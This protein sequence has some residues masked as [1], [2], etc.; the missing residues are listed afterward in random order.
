MPRQTFYI[1]LLLAYA[2]AALATVEGTFWDPSFDGEGW[3][4]ESQNDVAFVTWYTYESDGSPTFRAGI[5]D[6]TYQV[7]SIF[8]LT[9]TLTGDLFK[10]TDR[11]NSSRVGSFSMVFRSD[12]GSLVGT[13]NVLG[14]S[15]RIVPFAFNFSS[16]VDYFHGIWVV[17]LFG[18]VANDAQ[19]VLFSTV[20][21]TLTDGTPAKEYTI[22]ENNLPGFIYWEPLVNGFLAVTDQ[23]D[24]TFTVTQIQSSDD[25][26]IG[27]SVLTDGN[28]NVLSDS[29]FI[30]ATSI[31]NTEGEVRALSALL[32]IPTFKSA[33]QHNNFVRPSHEK[34]RQ[35]QQAFHATERGR[36]GKS[37][38]ETEP[39]NRDNR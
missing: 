18:T 19:T 12:T 34:I 15:R 5:A 25:K 10:V 28:F 35:I 38:V 7:S 20:E 13:V 24:G 32:G 31:A 21:T 1:I 29:V 27:V 8:D 37:S 11:T 4:I 9:V 30:I 17:A 33:M 3:A 16:A 14:E 6:V 2:Q 39:M 26:S 23:L 22:F 36:L